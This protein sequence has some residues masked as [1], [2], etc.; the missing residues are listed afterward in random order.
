MGQ[1]FIQGLPPFE[2]EPPPP[3]LFEIEPPPP[4]F[5]N[6][7]KVT[8]TKVTA[9]AKRVGISF[10]KHLIGSDREEGGLLAWHWS[11]KVSTPHASAARHNVDSL[12]WLSTS[13]HQWRLQFLARAMNA[14]SHGYEVNPPNCPIS[15]ATGWFWHASTQNS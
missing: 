2:I 7:H 13:H 9:V 12:L 6:Q 8:A 14:S 15:R 5:F 11:P 3:P 10:P 4:F 1:G